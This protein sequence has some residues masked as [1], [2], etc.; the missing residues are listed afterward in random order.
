MLIREKAP[1]VRGSLMLISF[2]VLLS[3]ICSPMF[4][5]EHGKALTGLQYADN[6]FNQLSK[7][8][9]YFIPG[10]REK[11]E[12]VKGSIVTITVPLKKPD[13]LPTAS[14]VLEKAGVQSVTTQDNKLTFT[15]DLGVL[16]SS[17]VDDSDALYHNDENKVSAK[18]NGEKAL[19]AASAWWY[20]LMPSL[21]ELQKQ[22]K[23]REAEVVD[24]VLRR[25]LEPGNNFFSIEPVKVSDH[26]LLLAGLLIFYL[27]YTLW[28]GFSIF[29]LFEGLGLAMS[30][31]KGKRG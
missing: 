23:I 19:K 12:T 21:K 31:P 15:A 24:Q 4:H 27:V 7:G 17:V 6:V 8:S 3:V 11:V 5:D 13:L 2:F 26:V 10:V 22:R 1:F 25:A 28:Y 9:S 18:Y 20:T 14:M 16:L 30:K 29:E